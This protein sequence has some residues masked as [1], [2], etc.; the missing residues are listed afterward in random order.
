MNIKCG[1]DL[2]F[3]PRIDQ[4]KK[5]ESLMAKFFHSNEIGNGTLEH[6]AGVV[7]AKE[8]FFKCLGVLPKFLEIEIMYEKTGKPKIVSP[9]YNSYYES[10]DLSITHE[11]NYA[12]A[13][14]VMI[15]I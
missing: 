1:I 10:L 5:D 9:S 4:I 2:V 7:A 15:C 8:A 6:L 13:M 12:S 14:V 11:K 3:I